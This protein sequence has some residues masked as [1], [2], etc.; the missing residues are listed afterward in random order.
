MTHSRSSSVTSL[1]SSSRQG[2]QR[3]PRPEIKALSPAHGPDT[4]GTRIIVTGAHFGASIEDIS[5]VSVGST[6]V[7]SSLC[8]ESSTRLTCVAPPGQN[9]V[10]VSVKT[11]KGGKSHNTLKFLYEPTSQPQSPSDHQSMSSS[12]SHSNIASR[13]VGSFR[14][15]STV[16]DIKFVPPALAK[17]DTV[18]L[19]PE[20]T[21]LSPINGS[22]DGG[23]TITIRGQHFGSNPDDIAS[24]KIAGVDC[25]ENI[26]S[27][28][29]STIKVVTGN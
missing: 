6:D 18:P 11:T 3:T 2:S 27:V 17:P 5:R 12:T 14:R 10:Y 22:S 16:P 26:V 24:L 29:N 13:L 1:S 9:S 7:S 19:P 20:I 4:G 21:G 8:W 15:T 25:R 23:D 28:E